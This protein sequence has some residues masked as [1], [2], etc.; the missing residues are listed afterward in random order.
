MNP[1][2]GNHTLDG[3]RYLKVYSLLVLHITICASY[4]NQNKNI[5]LAVCKL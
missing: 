1:Q 4:W 3:K 2:G 5:Y